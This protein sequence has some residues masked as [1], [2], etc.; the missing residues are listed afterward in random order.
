MRCF[1]A[2]VWS[3]LILGQSNAQEEYYNFEVWEA[4]YT[5]VGSQVLDIYQDHDGLIW[6]S[7]FNGVIRFDG[8]H[9]EHIADIYP[10]SEQI[11]T[12]HIS[13]VRKDK[14]NN[15]WIGTIGEGLFKLTPEGHFT[16]FNDDVIGSELLE[17]HRIEDIV[18]TD[19]LLFVEGRTGLSTFRINQGQFLKIN[20]ITGREDVEIRS[21][22]S[23]NDDL[24]F[25]TRN[26][27]LSLNGLIDEVDNILYPQVF[28]DK[29]GK[30][31]MTMKTDSGTTLFKLEDGDWSENENQPLL[32]ISPHR[33]FTWDY[34]ARLW[35]VKYND[36]LICYDFVKDSWIIKKGA[37]NHNLD[38]RIVRDVLVDNSGT[39]WV[40]SD[41]ISLFKKRQDIRSIKLPIANKDE[42][43]NFIF[44]NDR[45]LY[46]I[47]IDGLFIINPDG[48]F[49]NLRSDNSNLT[50][51]RFLK[52]AHLE[53]GK[54]GIAHSGGFQVL[55]SDNGFS[56]LV[57]FRGSNRSICVHDGYYW[58]GGVSKLIRIDPSTL[59]MKK[60]PLIGDKVTQNVYVNGLVTKSDNELYVGSSL[61]KLQIFN[62]ERGDFD[63]VKSG[64]NKI[65]PPNSCN[66]ISLSNNQILA[67]ASEN[68]LYTYDGENFDLHVPRKYFKSVEWANDS[69][70]IAST[71]DAIYKINIYNKKQSLI[72]Q[73]NGLLNSQ[74]ALRSVV[75]KGSELCFGGN[76]GLDCILLET[77]VDSL[78]TILNIESLVVNNDTKIKVD[79]NLEN[80]L[81]PQN[82]QHLAL[83]LNQIYTKS[84]NSA[85]ILYK[86][87]DGSSWQELSNNT[88]ILNNP[89]PGE[90]LFEFKSS[91]DD[92]AG[93][94]KSLKIEFEI[95]IP[96]YKHFLFWFLS[97]V[98]IITGIAYLVVKNQNK[99]KEK[100]LQDV[101]LKADIA[102]LR[103]KALSGQMNPHFTFNALN[104]ILQMIN[105][106]DTEN[107]SVYVQKFSRMLRFVL[108]YSDQSWV[109]LEKEIKFLEDYLHLEKMRFNES[110]D[111]A[112]SVSHPSKIGVIMIPPF[113][114]QPKIE[115][116]IKHGIRGLDQGGKIDI[117]LNIGEKLISASIVDNGIGR[118]AAKERNQF[119][120]ANTNKGFELTKDRLEQLIKLGYEASLHI[121]DLYDGAKPSGTQVELILP[122]KKETES[123]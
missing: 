89:R 120:N 74:F 10:E 11:P 41:V 60:Y 12:S 59:N 14:S 51:D 99:R 57:P 100:E 122:L 83:K 87:K 28:I 97:C 109:S 81:L 94:E 123:I 6:L 47:N 112:I 93:S 69:L 98:G 72:S 26:S 58:V 118:L 38:Q 18:I 92:Y 111:Y 86:S 88:L 103:L 101:Q 48:S 46:S 56:S 104:S 44:D 30:L 37:E 33:R 108:E 63:I 80:V 85:R 49:S 77:P 78:S 73:D 105:E 62:I 5:K 27:I 102:E 106:N 65:Q 39:V 34:R 96:W 31:W 121:K 53:E 61:I 110:F 42:I 35:G 54:I 70:M 24:L 22:L 117:K 19:S 90:H 13:C 66:H 20:D 107:A 76:N 36:N 8:S 2:I 25:T 95:P 40:G 75:K 21:I 1:F 114:L 79:T 119:Q 116:A 52:F 91:I 55:N 9:F 50:N 43:V 67:L 71:K 29:E 16:S 15:I 84:Q 3:I 17:E 113:F 82:T 45:L 68:G 7:T 32:N 23:Y 4:G 64:P 115:N